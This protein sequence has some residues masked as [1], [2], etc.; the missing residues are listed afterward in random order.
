[1]LGGLVQRLQFRLEFGEPRLHLCALGFER[2]VGLESFE[3]GACL[4]KLLGRPRLEGEIDQRAQISGPQ[5]EIPGLGIRDL[6]RPLGLRKARVLFKPRQL[7]CGLNHLP[8][9]GQGFVAPGLPRRQRRARGVGRRPFRRRHRSLLPRLEL[10]PHHGLLAQKAVRISERGRISDPVQQPRG[11]SGDLEQV[12]VAEDRSLG[13]LVPR[14]QR[15]NADD[16]HDHEL[17]G[18]APQHP[19]VAAPGRPLGGVFLLGL[20]CVVCGVGHTAIPFQLRFPASASG[21]SIPS[22]ARTAQLPFEGNARPARDLTRAPDF[23]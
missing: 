16:E 6:L 10:P 23:W 14:Q 5:P 15:Q 21:L 3:L 9:F 17:E 8:T 1:M 22:P 7:L 13:V 20:G 18:P 2:R 4:F 12:P 11:A 19:F